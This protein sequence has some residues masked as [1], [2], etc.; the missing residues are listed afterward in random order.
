MSVSQEIAELL[1]SEA[2][3][4]NTPAFIDDDPVQF[5]RRFDDL[6]DIEIAG[7]LSATIAWGNRKMICRNCNKMLELMDHLPYRYMMDE[8]YEELP[9]RLNIHR[10][11]FARNL[12]HYLRGLRAIY[13]EYGSLHG[14]AKHLQIN[15]SEAPAWTLAEAMNSRFAAANGGATDSR[16]LPQNLKDTALKRLNMWMRWMVRDDGIVD[17]G[18]WRDIVSPSQLFLPLDVHVAD[19]SRELGLLGRRSNDRRAVIELTETL[20]TLR[21]EDP[22]LYD[23][24]LFG[25]GMKL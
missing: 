20:R 11:F 19:T 21:P 2:R 22:C 3:R 25:I 6:R 9:D 13:T 24:A 1:E 5:P 16:C 12:K 18:V 23:Y 14:F 8:G 17:L 4:I 10:T 7:L 15:A